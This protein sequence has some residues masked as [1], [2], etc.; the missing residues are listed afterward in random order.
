MSREELQ[1]LPIKSHSNIG[2][3]VTKCLSLLTAKPDPSNPSPQPLILELHADAKVAGKAITITE[4]VKRRLKEAG[5]DVTQTTSVREKPAAVVGEE[6]GKDVVR[7]H[8]QGEGYG[9]EKE[10]KKPDV[11][12][13]IRLEMDVE[14]EG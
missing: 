11:Q 8:L 9:K 2:K 3:V 7:K 12:L 4:I 13:V 10:K 6:K 1:T 5:R 14:T